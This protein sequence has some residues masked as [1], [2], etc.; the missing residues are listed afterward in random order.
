MK[1]L[2][3]LLLVAFFLVS[4]HVAISEAALLPSAG[5]YM[6]KDSSTE[7]SENRDIFK[8]NEKPF[9]FVQFLISDIGK[10]LD[11]DWTWKYGS[12]VI[13]TG[14]QT[15]DSFTAGDTFYNNYKGLDDWGILKIGRTTEDWSVTALW[16]SPGAGGGSQALSFKLENENAAVI[17]EPASSVLFLLG[18]SMLAI[19]ARRRNT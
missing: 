13:W 7:P 12:D 11:L 9:Y 4:I 18:G 19:R 6:T 5:P 8:W 1:K 3:Y 17:P 14:T 10:K 15:I 2:F 16:N